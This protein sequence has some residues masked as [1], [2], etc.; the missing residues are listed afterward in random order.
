MDKGTYLTILQEA[1]A[2]LPELLRDSDGWHSLDVDYEPPRVQRL[3]RPIDETHP[4]HRLYLHW[5]APCEKALYHPHPWPSAIEIVFG[6]YEM[7]V[8]YGT[9]AEDPQE[10]A[11]VILAAG[12]SYEMVEPNGWH[13]VRPLRVPS[14]SLMV[15]GP[16]WA[17][18]HPGLKSPQGKQ[19]QPLSEE[20]KRNLLGMFKLKLCW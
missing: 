17:N 9:S 7:G 16:P 15:T 8:G 1:K 18:R 4:G 6:T 2:R 20:A 11:T 14:L 19:L 13:Y 10:A 12:S 3:W 5:I